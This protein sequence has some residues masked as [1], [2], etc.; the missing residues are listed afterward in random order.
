MSRAGELNLWDNDLKVSQFTIA[1][2]VFMNGPRPDNSCPV[3]GFPQVCFIK[4]T[5]KNP[6]IIVG[7][8]SYYDDPDGPEK[9]EQN[10]L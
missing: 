7:D 3:E 5:I 4:N 9:F 10:V 6:N 8:Y 2:G 1:Q